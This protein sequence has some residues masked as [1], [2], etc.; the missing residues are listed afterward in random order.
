MEQPQA[1][2]PNSK[3]HGVMATA[4]P[5]LNNRQFRELEELLTEYEDIFARDSEDYG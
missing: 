5:N 3:L 2:D 4:R 1:Q